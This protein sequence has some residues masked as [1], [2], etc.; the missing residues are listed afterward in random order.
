MAP[1]LGLKSLV[2]VILLGSLI[3]TNQAAGAR[4]DMTKL[5]KQ[6]HKRQAKTIHASWGDT[7]DCVEFHKQPAFDHPLLKDHKIQMKE[8]LSS[9]SLPK[10]GKN[11]IDECPKGTVPIRRT[12]REDL[13]ASKLSVNYTGSQYRAGVTYNTKLGETIYG[14]SGVMNVWNPQ[15]NEDQF[16][17]GEIALQSGSQ[18]QEEA[19]II[20]FGW[21]VNPQLYGEHVTR[22]FAYWTSDGGKTGCYN[23]VCPGFVQVHSKHTPDSAFPTTSEFE[24]TQILFTVQITLDKE[25]GKWWLVGN[26]EAIGYWPRELFP[27]FAPGATSVFWG[28]RVMSGIDRLSPPMGSGKPLNDYVLD[29]AGFMLSIRYIDMN[30]NQNIL[31]EATE[32]TI[33]C[34]EYYNVTY[35]PEHG[36][37]YF[38]GTGGLNCI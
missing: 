21:T 17:S 22:S 30:N 35:I 5:E 24:G 3:F 34:L 28:G 9:V 10:T 6:L 37:V 1:L 7:Y 33:D 36:N 13:I 26:G 18:P 8:E 32:P 31:P 12:T 14:A 23:T 20:K 19:T 11:Q 4:V 15:V 2:F 25:G 29:D 38:G 16:S 27:A